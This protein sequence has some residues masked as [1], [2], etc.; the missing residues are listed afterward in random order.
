MWFDFIGA[1]LIILAK[2]NLCRCPCW[3]VLS[4]HCWKAW[5]SFLCLIAI[6][7][8]SMLNILVYFYDSGRFLS[9]TVISWFLNILGLTG[10][11]V[12]FC[13][14]KKYPVLSYQWFVQLDPW[15]VWFI[16]VSRISHYVIFNYKIHNTLECRYNAVMRSHDQGVVISIQ[17]PYNFIKHPQICCILCHR[18][19]LHEYS[20]IIEFIKLVWEK[21]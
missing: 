17:V 1:V 3:I 5:S 2:T 18:E 12:V 10:H 11:T 13:W 19:F 7:L 8:Q 16:L 15:E 21:R 14:A 6:E 20:C 9:Q 4:L